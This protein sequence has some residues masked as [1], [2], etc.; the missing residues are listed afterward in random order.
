MTTP[1]PHMTTPPQSTMEHTQMSADMF[2]LYLHQNYIEF[3]DDMDDV[4]RRT[5]GM[6]VMNL[7]E[8]A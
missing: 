7:R 6:C 4:V 2:I 5:T 1:T 8:T 3:F